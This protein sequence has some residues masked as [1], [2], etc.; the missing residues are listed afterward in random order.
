MKR[1]DS[2]QLMPQ[3]MGAAA[4][5]FAAGEDSA[6]RQAMFGT[7]ISQSLVIDGATPRRC[8]TGMERRYGT[9][10]FS[11]K[12]PCNG[13]IR[14]LV[15]KFPR[16]E[17]A[18]AIKMNPST[19]V[20]FE[21][22]LNRNALDMVEIPYHHC[23]HN[24][25]GF[26]Y[27][28]TDAG[29]S[30]TTRISVEKGTI[31]ADS[32]SVDRHGNYNMGVELNTVY[33]SVPGTIEDGVIISESAIEKL[34]STGFE[35]RNGSWGK[36][37]YPLNLYGTKDNYK[38]FP[39]IGETI[40]EDGL[41]FAFREYDVLLAGVEMCEDQLRTVDHL[42]DRR[43]YAIPG[44]KVVNVT[45][46]KG[47]SN[48]KPKT[49]VGMDVQAAKYHEAECNFYNEIT[50]TVEQMQK[51]TGVQVSPRLHRLI[52]EGYFFRNEPVRGVRPK[53]MYNLQEIDEWR[54]DIT[55]EYKVRPNIGSKITN[56]HGGKGV[57]C[58]IWP[59]ANMPVDKFGTVAEIIMDANSI[60]K[61]MN[62]GGLYEQ[63][64][65][66]H[67]DQI[68]RE[69]LKMR[70]A[71]PKGFYTPAWAY[72][73]QYYKL[74]SPNILD[75]L[76][77]P[78]EY[79]GTPKHHIDTIVRETVGNWLPL[80]SPVTLENGARA[81]RREMP[82]DKGPLTYIGPSGNKVTTKRD[83]IIGS[84]YYLVLEKLGDDW[85]S[86]AS[87]KLQHFGF[88]AKINKHDKHSESTR[89][90]PVRIHGESEVRLE[91]AVC[92]SQTVARVIEFS[93]SPPLHKHITSNI[94]HSSTPSNIESV[95]TDSKLL[96]RG[97]RNLALVYHSLQISG[98][99]LIR[100][101]RPS[102]LPKI[103]EASPEEPTL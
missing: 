83:I 13:E 80:E 45:A 8:F 81:L 18:D 40:R 52:V 74:L 85:S 54:V 72:L 33:A 59:T 82:L 56:T 89:S 62:P 43:V 42:F 50:R 68:R 95:V 88:P 26:K 2:R 77:S 14:A 7:Q 10:T 30:L 98:V 39:D 87:T 91:V 51:R 24:H 73:T 3:L 64:F 99:A 76:N 97:G 6:P 1:E 86:V 60:L 22:V 67:G 44:A 69:I 78:T 31:L 28:L 17:G 16:T 41:L 37:R 66:A 20:I 102:D 38:P 57:I 25:Y 90:M 84:V 63:Y 100:D 92:G 11:V 48:Q 70:D 46:R 21:D 101:P 5:S 94:M 34:T 58:A 4:L 29:E 19:V 9:A 47:T 35:K 75:V 32:P 71:D 96:D 93:N 61:R 103:Y 79:H 15:E 23:K 65:N 53:Q 27:K 55:F 36:K 49:P 12:M